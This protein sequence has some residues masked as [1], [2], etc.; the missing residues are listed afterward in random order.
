MAKVRERLG[1]EKLT[2][3][4]IE[5]LMK[6]RAQRKE[7]LYL[8]VPLSIAGGLSHL[9]ASACWCYLVLHSV[10]EL[11]PSHGGYFWLRADFEEAIG[12]GPRWWF[13][14]TNTL[15]AAGVIDVKRAVG[16]KPRYRLLPLSR[17]KKPR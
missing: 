7:A 2:T 16:K 1:E 3:P 14:Y 5:R 4:T 6:E 11:S 17:W 13:E 12:R 10:R 15:A 8:R 9:G